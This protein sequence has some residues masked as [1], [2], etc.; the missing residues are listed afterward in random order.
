MCGIFGYSGHDLDVADVERAVS[1]LRHRGPDGTGAYLDSQRRVGLGHARLS[2][3]DLAG[4]RQ[5][6]LSEARD[7]ALVCNGEIYDFERLRAELQARGHVFETG[8]DSE[9][10]IHL[11]EQYGP[12]FVRHLRGEFAFLLYDK[13]RAKLLAVRDRFGIKPLFFHQ[14]DGRYLFASEAKALFATRILRPS[15]DVHAVRDYLCGV[16]PDSIFERVRV[17]PPGCILTVDVERGTHSVSQYWDLDLPADGAAHNAGELARHAEAVRES[18][19]EAVRLRLRADVPVGVYLSGGI[20]SAIVAAVA[21]KYFPDRL[22]VFSIEFPGDHAFNELSLA[23]RMA[24][25]IGAEF[26]SITCDRDT[27][28]RHTEECLW[29]TELPFINFHGVGKYL[30]SKLAREHVTVVLTGEGS[31]EVFLGYV[32]F[33]PGKGAMSD[34]VGDR[35]TAIKV[36]NGRRVKRI[37]DA[38]GFVP[39]PEHAMTFT[40]M[41]Q[42]AIRT[43]FHPKHRRA[44]RASHPLDR[45]LTRLDR[46]QT[47]G[48]PFARQVQYFWI[49][50][51]LAPYLLCMLGDRVEMGHSIEGRTPFLDHHL[52]ELAR[53]I[54]DC[55]KIHNGVEKYVLREAFKDDLTDELYRR[56]KWPYSAPPLRVVKGESSELDRLMDEFLS[57]EAVERAGIFDYHAIRRIRTLARLVPFDIRFKRSINIG[58]VFA[59]T[60]QILDRLFVQDFDANLEK[61][62]AA[63]MLPAELPT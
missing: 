31:D 47:D 18:F 44:L 15:V 12:D 57:K 25:R 16:V 61:R 60:V 41:Q 40:T 38:L 5:P 6:L 24:D 27:L 22:K 26:H 36:P 43:A 49:K 7:I 20:D 28:L 14:Q 63:R 33:Q 50:S 13:G 4:G 42:F 30:L 34:Q 37:V 21:A 17:V 45:I 9:V 46:R 58:L 35:L 8:S 54:P 59:L 29:A 48:R 2:I 51:M 53:Q 10:I 11:Y 56:E 62:L 19:E 3:I 55:Y 32:Y 39:L 23:K 52:F 1:T